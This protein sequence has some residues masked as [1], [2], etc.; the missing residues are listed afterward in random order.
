V[1]E[2]FHLGTVLSVT[3]DRFVSPQGFGD[4]HRLLDHL[5]GDTL[6]THQ[7]PR[8]SKECKPYLLERFAQLADVPLPAEFASPTHVWD[9]LAEQAAIHGEWLDVEPMP[10]V[11]HT[12]I[13]PLTELSMIAPHMEVITVALPEAGESS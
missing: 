5:T 8:A 13:N 2:R 4:V 10:A 7:L 9:W 6:F 3:T 11:N 12:R 1:S